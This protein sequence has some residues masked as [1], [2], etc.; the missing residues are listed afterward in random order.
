MYFFSPDEEGRGMVVNWQGLI[1]VIAFYILILLIGIYASWKSKAFKKETNS[2]DVMVANRGIG[3][4]VGMFTMTGWPPQL[5]LAIN[6]ILETLQQLLAIYGIK[7]SL[8][9]IYYKYIIIKYK[10]L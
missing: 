7:G 6:Y 8:N 10:L 9:D 3:L 1:G 2:E 5:D 4:F